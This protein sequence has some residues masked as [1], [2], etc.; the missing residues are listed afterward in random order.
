VQGQQQPVA[1]H[2][3]PPVVPPLPRA[4][5]AAVAPPEWSDTPLDLPRG[6]EEAEEAEE[7]SPWLRSGPAVWR[8]TAQLD[9]GDAGAGDAGEPLYDSDGG[10]AASVASSGGNPMMSAPISPRYDEAHA[11]Q[12]SVVEVP[13]GEATSW[14]EDDLPFGFAGAAAAGAAAGWDDAPRA[15]FAKYSEGGGSSGQGHE[16]SPGDSWALPPDAGGPAAAPALPA[17]ILRGSAEW[18]PEPEAAAAG[19]RGSKRVSFSL[20]ASPCASHSRGGRQDAAWAGAAASWD[21]P[22]SAA[23]QRDEVTPDADAQA[24]G[25]QQYNEQYDEEEAQNEEEDHLPVYGEPQQAPAAQPRPLGRAAAGAAA[26]AG[27][28]LQKAALLLANAARVRRSWQQRGEAR[29]GADESFAVELGGTPQEASYGDAPELG[30]QQEGTP[31]GA[32]RAWMAEDAAHGDGADH[33]SPGG[34]ACAQ[35]SGSALTAQR[36][37]ELQQALVAE[38]RRSL[39]ALPG[40]PAGALPGLPADR[41]LNID[42]LMSA[43]IANANNTP[44]GP[45]ARGVREGNHNLFDDEKAGALRREAQ[46]RGRQ[47]ALL[48]PIVPAPLGMGVRASETVAHG[49][50]PATLRHSLHTHLKAAS[51]GPASA[52]AAAGPGRRASQAS[53]GAA[54]RGGAAGAALGESARASA[55]AGQQQRRQS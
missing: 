47:R 54:A 3:S 2:P 32:A 21:Q 45:L 50:S 37:C 17:G 35:A 34:S 24:G 36:S 8:S 6:E 14:R 7:G 48:E 18:A 33:E 5:A 51:A 39:P 43:V 49:I 11:Q 46:A 23:G 15:S 1:F 4:G 12:R 9:A 40:V 55:A 22:Y 53:S 30:S 20:P 42:A 16:D 31:L 38:I 52:A 19:V 10:G 29:S 41:R 44:T 13:P 26:A 27:I 28:D 25:E